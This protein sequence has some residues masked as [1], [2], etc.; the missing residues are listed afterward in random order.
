MNRRP[1]RTLLRSL[2]CLASLLASLSVPLRLL[3]AADSHVF[4]SSA[5][6]KQL[7][8]YRLRGETGELALRQT[9]DL[10]AE[11][12]PLITTPDRTRLFAGFR[13]TGQLAS[14]TLHPAT[15]QVKPVNVVEAGPDPAHITVDPTGRYLLTAYYVA[16]KVSVHEIACDGSLS[17]KPR[18]EIATADKAHAIRFDRAGRFAFAP[19][20]GT[21]RIE[22]FV[23]NAN[24][25]RLARNPAGRIDL[26][27]Q[28]GPRH[29][30]WHPTLPLAFVDNEQ[31][32]SVTPYRLD[33]T[34]G[35]LQP[36]TTQ[37]TLPADFPG[38]NACAEI[39]VHPSGRFVYASNRGHDSL[40]GFAIDRDGQL[41]S[42]GQ[43]P[44]EATPRSFDITPDGRFL[45]AAGESS[46]ALRVY[47]VDTKSGRLESQRRYEVAP[48]LWWVLIVP[49]AEEPGAQQ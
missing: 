5:T 6:N 47:S 24:D 4:V 31:A 40:A 18:Q 49:A 37:S 45:V 1:Y 29:L 30:D 21:N 16:A 27:E 10:T 41:R 20:T 11:P 9:L 14:F 35:T 46:G 32:S 42:L 2:A 39:K 36:L 26:P 15:G 33:T 23:W 28:T 8:V 34:A 44:T 22:Q 7:L 17:A 19:H 48:R 38:T 25:G 43:F 3:D 12:A 13:S